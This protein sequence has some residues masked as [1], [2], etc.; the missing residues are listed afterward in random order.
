MPSVRISTLIIVLLIAAIP[1]FVLG[2]WYEVHNLGLGDSAMPEQGAWQYAE[3][4][5]SPYLLLSSNN[6]IMALEVNTGKLRNGYLGEN[7]FYGGFGMPA[8]G[9]GWDL[10]YRPGGTT[11]RLH[12]NSHGE[13]GDDIPLGLPTE[14]FVIPLPVPE[15]GKIWF[16]STKIFRLDTATLEYTAY[17]YPEGIYSDISYIYLYPSD[18]KNTLVACV[19]SESHIGYQGFWMNLG[20]GES[21]LIDASPDFFQWIDD[22]REW[23]AKP[24]SFLIAKDNILWTY[25]PASDEI[26]L[27]IEE[28]PGYLQNI[29]QESSG[30]FLYTVGDGNMLY[31]TDLF[32]KTTASY[33]LDLREGDSILFSGQTDTMFDP[34][35]NKII[36][37]V[38]PGWD[39]TLA[40]IDLEDKSVEYLD[41]IPGNVGLKVVFLRR[42]NKLLTNV[43]SSI[44]II[45][46][47]T[48]EV[49]TSISL[50]NHSSTWGTC[51]GEATPTLIPEKNTMFF[52]RLGPLG[53]LEIHNAGEG[54]RLRNAYMY[55]GSNIALM[56]IDMD[57]N[58]Y[59]YR[60]YNF[61]DNTTEDIELPLNI[62]SWFPDP[63]HEQII[64]FTKYTEGSGS[65]QFLKPH[66]RARVFR[67]AEDESITGSKLIFA[68]EEEAAWAVLANLETDEYFFYKLSTATG[69]ILDSFSL[70]PGEISY[71][72][73]IKLD[74]AGRYLYFINYNRIDDWTSDRLLVVLDTEKREVVA[75]YTIQTNA[76]KYFHFV[77]VPGIIPIPGQDKVFV[78]NHYGGWC[79]DTKTWEVLYGETKDNPENEYHRISYI[80]GYWDEER[81]LVVVVDLSYGPNPKR[82]I[83]VQ[84]ASGEV[85]REIPLPDEDITKVFFPSDKSKIFLLSWDKARY[86]TYNLTPEWERPARITTQT[87]F[88]Q[89][90]PGDSARFSLRIQNPTFQRATLYAWICIPN[91]GYL[92]FNGLG[93]SPEITGIPLTLPAGLDV[94]AD[95][96]NFE[97][98]EIMPEGM[99]NFNAIFLSEDRGFGPMGTWNFY[100]GD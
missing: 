58:D 94:S 44:C 48:K 67:L 95:I 90:T 27:L 56:K 7:N 83:E 80:D 59:V 43:G 79:I 81:E 69:E 86:F 57:L 9:D 100:V 99:Y 28:L 15:T 24:G 47:N 87:N 52:K 78:W 96:V 73:G 5:E 97:I 98:P 10:Y 36:I 51:I 16:F 41:A 25:D 17:D 46:L 19:K 66:G 92:F 62:N 40:V 23:Y 32:E 30:R 89:Y 88:L 18:D 12:V 8:E 68:P 42:E 71:P 50:K 21:K 31:I 53:R 54:K 14:D 55:P 2:E 1:G 77:A 70:P 20:T 74:P 39:M 91:G 64:T 4:P 22:I 13:F 38:S 76:G 63:A 29:M 60:E 82:I 45:D 84:L 85:W 3:L 35:R 37:F 61:D 11:W 72:G 93:F 6:Y 33:E 34:D 26:E 65:V 75:R 49:K